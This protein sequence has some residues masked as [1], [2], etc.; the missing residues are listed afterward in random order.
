MRVTGHVACEKTEVDLVPLVVDVDGT[1]V[2]TDLL[3]ETVLQFVAHH[4]FQLWRIPLWLIGGKSR[5]KRALSD[6]VNLDLSTIPLREE[7]LALIK[8]AKAEG[9]PVFLASASE[10]GLVRKLADRIHGIEGV[11][12]TDEAGNLAGAEKSKRLN[13]TFGEGRY[14]YVGDRQIDFAVWPSARQVF[15][16]SHS[17]RFSDRL[18]QSYPDATIIAEGTIRAEPYL[19]ALRLHQWAKNALV[20]LSMIVGHHFEVETI[21][22]TVLAFLCFCFAASGAY[23]TNDLLDLPADRDH[24]RKHTR[25]FAAGDIPIAHGVTLSLLL[26][27]SSLTASLLLPG[28]FTAILLLYVA[29]TFAYSFVLKRRLLIDVVA[30]GGLYTIRVLGGIAAA[31]STYSPWL[32]MFC[33]LLFLSLAIVKRCSELVAR[34]NLGKAASLGRSYQVE[35]L[36]ILLPLGAAAGYGAALVVMLYLSSPEVRVLYAHPTR[37]WL[38][39]PLVLYW[40]SRMLMLSNR[41][42]LHDDPVVFALMDR[43]TWFMGVIAAGIIAVSI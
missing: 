40:I 9:R 34:R 15:A 2:K 20:F 26:L 6:R 42:E 18:R 19:R 37:M 12:G 24:H 30:L 35:D 11:F 21:Q 17:P 28:R 27:L 25:P 31:A 41:G 16:V 14:D 33:L 13:A 29:C 38:I 3:H 1:L 36:N 23:I 8:A 43:T 32:L 10:E 5:L 4:P 22:A 7:T 39:C